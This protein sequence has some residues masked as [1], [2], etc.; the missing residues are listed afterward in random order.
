MVATL[1]K[2]APVSIPLD[3]AI[4]SSLVDEW[5]IDP[6]EFMAREELRTLI[7]RILSNL[8]PCQKQALE[9]RFGFRDGQERSFEEVRVGC[10]LKDGQHARR[11]VAKA[12]R[13]IRCAIRNSPELRREL[14]EDFLK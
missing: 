14:Q 3:E 10:G 6:V 13:M 12:L 11:V 4:L 9:L 5:P 1:V 8:T 2:E 7:E